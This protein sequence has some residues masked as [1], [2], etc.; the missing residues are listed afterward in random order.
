[1]SRHWIAPL[2]AAPLVGLGIWLWHDQ[3]AMIALAD[4]AAACF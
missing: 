1:M 2:I 3:G 4:F